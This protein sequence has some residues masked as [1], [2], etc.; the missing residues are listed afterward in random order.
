MNKMIE[1]QKHFLKLL[2]ADGYTFEQLTEAYNR[3]FM[4]DV[5]YKYGLELY[6]FDIFSNGL[7]DLVKRNI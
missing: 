1:K 4:D 2:K 7:E 5:V 6:G 3:G